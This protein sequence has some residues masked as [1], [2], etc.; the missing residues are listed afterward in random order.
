M[1]KVIEKITDELFYVFPS[2]NKSKMLNVAN[3]I[4]DKEI[5]FENGDKFLK[6]KLYALTYCGE[7]EDALNEVKKGLMLYP[8]DYELHIA[9]GL[10]GKILN[11]GTN[12]YNKAL[13]IIEETLKNNQSDVLIITK[14]YLLLFDVK[15]DS[16]VL[17]QYKNNEFVYG[18]LSLFSTLQK[19]ELSFAPPIHFILTKPLYYRIK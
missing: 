18:A 9:K 12:S 15:I 1:R 19:D 13:E 6:L 7:Y 2:M 3:K 10:L 5:M 4:T 8:D 17:E 11:Y 16:N 14:Y